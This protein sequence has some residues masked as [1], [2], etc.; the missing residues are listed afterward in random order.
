[1]I[2]H[3]R[4]C[5][6]RHIFEGEHAAAQAACRDRLG[7]FGNG[8]VEVSIRVQ[9]ERDEVVHLRLGDVR[10]REA[11]RK[12]SM[13]WADASDARFPVFLAGKGESQVEMDAGAFQ[14]HAP[15]LP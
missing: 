3:C 12:S 11:R 7:Q 2:V 8:T 4:R 10:L 6:A 14:R 9:V 5:P 13:D 1:M 15:L